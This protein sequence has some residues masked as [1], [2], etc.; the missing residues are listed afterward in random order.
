MG[1]KN[2]NKLDLLI[3]KEK[4]PAPAYKGEINGTVEPVFKGEIDGTLV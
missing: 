1:R 4:E 2:K 3:F